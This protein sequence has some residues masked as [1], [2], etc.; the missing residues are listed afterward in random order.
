MLNLSKQRPPEVL[1]FGRLFCDVVFTGLERMPTPGTEIFGSGLQLNAGGGASITSAYLTA[2][3][4]SAMPVAKLGNDVFSGE[5]IRSLDNANVPL[6]GLI[7]VECSAPQLTIAMPLNG[8]RAFVTNLSGLDFIE[9]RREILNVSAAR[10]LHICEISTL[11]AMPDLPDFAHEAGMTVSLDCQWDETI[12]QDANTLASIEKV[13]VFLPNVDELCALG[14]HEGDYEMAFSRWA[15]KIDLLVVK[16]GSYGAEAIQNNR[17]VRKTVKSAQVI[18]AT[19]AGD[20]FNAGFLD[21]WLRGEPI[22]NC[23]DLG[24]LCGMTAVGHIG[25]LGGLDELS[26]VAGENVA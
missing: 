18:D 10:H 25:G 6:D 17:R 12:M 23:L 9:D 22:E 20:A 16:R 21:A 26:R 4:R 24:N 15:N 8:D 2:L 14:D 11:H 5:V 1:V 19:G 7:H 13:D 3:G